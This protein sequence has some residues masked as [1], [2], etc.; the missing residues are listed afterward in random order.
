VRFL[1]LFALLLAGCAARAVPLEPLAAAPEGYALAGRM[2][3]KVRAPGLSGT[4]Q[5]SLVLCRPDRLFLQVRSP[6]G[7]VLAQGTIDARRAALVVPPEARAFVA[8]APEA[9]LRTLTGGALGVDG[10]LALLTARLPADLRRVGEPSALAFEAPGGRRVLAHVD[11]RGRLAGVDLLGPD[12]ATLATLR[13]AGRRRAG[14]LPLPRRIA[15][16]IPGLGLAA[17]ADLHSWEILGEVP[18]IFTTA[19]PPGF[20]VRPI[21]ALPG[22]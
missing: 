21:D 7:P 17:E 19:I 22:G 16:R 1:L 4:V 8:D 10:L 13:Y 5:A 14:R 20:E 3:L 2:A 15:A 11:R 9:A 6:L 18:A 12:E